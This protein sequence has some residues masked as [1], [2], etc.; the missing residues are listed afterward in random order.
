[1][2]TLPDDP[3]LIDDAS[4]P[5]INFNFGPTRLIFAPPQI[6]KIRSARAA[7]SRFVQL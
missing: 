2:L 5:D 7:D 6:G 3:P 4:R 1:M